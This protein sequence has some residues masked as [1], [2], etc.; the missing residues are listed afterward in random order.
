ML[1]QKRSVLISESP[2]I[3]HAYIH[4]LCIVSTSRDAPHHTKFGSSH[5][6]A[7]KHG[8]GGVGDNTS[9]EYLASKKRKIAPA[10]PP[11]VY[12]GF[13][14]TI[15]AAAAAES[16][17][18]PPPSYKPHPPASY[19]TGLSRKASSTSSRDNRSKG[20]QFSLPASKRTG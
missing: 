14:S 5:Y 12:A 7:H 10:A 3:T 19:A 6:S 8:S 2:H 11:A 17:R 1:G 4:D 13:S 15:T 18:D 20:Y 16:S 9:E